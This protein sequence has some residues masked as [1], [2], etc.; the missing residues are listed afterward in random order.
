MI[1]RF[2]LIDLQKIVFIIVEYKF[3]LVIYYVLIEISYVL[4]Y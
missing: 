1:D 4:N 3:F 2:K